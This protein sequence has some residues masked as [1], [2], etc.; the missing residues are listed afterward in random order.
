MV[1]SCSSIFLIESLSFTYTANGKRQIQ[2]EN[3]SKKKMSRLKLKTAKKICMDIK[4]KGTLGHVVQNR[5]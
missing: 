3:Y 5:V 1:N 4:L 2:V